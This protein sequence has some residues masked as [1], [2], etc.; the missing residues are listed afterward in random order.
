VVS[1]REIELI[2]KPSRERNAGFSN[3]TRKMSDKSGGVA[4]ATLRDLSRNL[5]QL[6]PKSLRCSREGFEMSSKGIP[7]PQILS[8][9][10]AGVSIACM[11]WSTSTKGASMKYFRTAQKRA[12]FSGAASPGGDQ[13]IGR[14]CAL[15]TG[16]MKKI[17]WASCLI[18]NDFGIDAEGHRAV[19]RSSPFMHIA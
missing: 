11:L 3:E 17:S 16:G 5:T 18:L 1:H 14:M 6:Q 7:H 12:A 19:E 10:I 13:R 15:G 9:P 2:S 4:V 8:A